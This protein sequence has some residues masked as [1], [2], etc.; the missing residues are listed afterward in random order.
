MPFGHVPSPLLVVLLPN[1]KRH[2]PRCCSRVA[3]EC[4]ILL[5]DAF[6]PPERRELLRRATGH[7]KH[8]WVLRLVERNEVSSGDHDSLIRA[9]AV[10]YTRMSKQSLTIHGRNCWSEAQFDAIPGSGTT[11]IWRLGRASIEEFFLSPHA[12]VQALGDWELRRED[13]HW[14]GD[15]HPPSWGHYRTGQQDFEQ[16]QWEG[17]VAAIDGSVDRKREVMGAGVV[18]GKGQAPDFTLPFPVGGPLPTL[19]SEACSI[20][21]SWGTSK[22][23]RRGRTTF[24]VY[25]LPS[26]PR[27]LSPL[28]T[29]GLLAR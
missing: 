22:A 19:R 27:H 10:L 5:L 26:P 18:V 21:C 29:G 13:F 14:P 24:G 11:E 7:G 9:G 4:G 3:A 8:V 1:A 20:C 25:R 12:F 17:L 6:P 2:G 28:G 16:E 23:C 15:G